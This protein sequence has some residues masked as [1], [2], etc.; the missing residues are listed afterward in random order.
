VIVTQNPAYSNMGL[1]NSEYFRR[2]LIVPLR[3]LP[4]T[5]IDRQDW[6]YRNTM[7]NCQVI[8]KSEVQAVD[9]DL[10]GTTSSRFRSQE[11]D[12][13]RFQ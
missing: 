5:V 1:V 3:V 8:V 11:S 9:N 2:I 13:P 4:R 7:E 12:L 6:P 10:V